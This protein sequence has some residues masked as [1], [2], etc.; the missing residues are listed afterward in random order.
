MSETANLTIKLPLSLKETIKS[1]AEINN[2]TLSAE[3]T[4]RLLHSLANNQ[5][6]R[7]DPDIS[8]DSQHT[9][10]IIEQGLTGDE[11][12]QVRQLLLLKSKK[13]HKKK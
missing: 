1:Q 10:E 11:I 5:A 9:R 7:P 4:Q 12:K 8:I 13:T 2:C 6:V 3:I